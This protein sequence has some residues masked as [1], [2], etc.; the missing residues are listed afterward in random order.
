LLGGVDGVS[1]ECALEELLP[2][3]VGRRGDEGKGYEAEQLDD[4]E[5]DGALRKTVCQPAGLGAG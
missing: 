3:E 2:V 4:V 1:R 5:G